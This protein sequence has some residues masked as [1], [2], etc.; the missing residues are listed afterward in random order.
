M[1]TDIWRDQA[2][3]YFCISTKTRDGVWRDKLFR[4][5]QLDLV[6]QY[7]RERRDRNVYFCPH[8]FSDQYAVLPRLLWSD[9]DIVDPRDVS[10]TPTIAIESSPGRYVGLWICDDVVTEELNRR[11]T[12]ALGCDRSGWDLT[13]VL[14]FPGTINYKYAAMPRVRVMWRDG[15]QYRVRD[16][17]RSLP[18]LASVELT[19]GG[20]DIDFDA[21]RSLVP[22]VRRK[23]PRISLALG[24]APMLNAEGRPDRSATWMWQAGL[25]REAGASD[26]EMAAMLTMCR[27]TFA[28]KFPD[29]FDDKR[30]RA[31]MERVCSKL[32]K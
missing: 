7:V 22:T 1:I 24:A 28:D 31:E 6:A 23:F 30:A 32:E 9:M 18:K 13:Q 19:H 21:A 12:Y 10:L 4:R 14:R 5:S 15:P 27:R 8:G 16:L 11:L 20:G 17:S 26:E 2:G 3:K 29:G 25:M